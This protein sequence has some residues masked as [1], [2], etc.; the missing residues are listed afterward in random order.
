MS[1]SRFRGQLLC[2]QFLNCNSHEE[3][4][5][6]KFSDLILNKSQA[7]AYS[8]KLRQNA[9]DLFY[10]GFI[11]LNEGLIGIENKQ[12]SWAVVKCYYSIFYLLRAD[13]ALKDFGIIRH[14]SLYYLFAEEG[15]SPITKGNRNYSTDHKCVINYHKD[16][17]SNSDILL[18]QNISDLNAYD[19]LSKKRE[20]I[21]YQE[22]FFNEP[23]APSFLSYIDGVIKE[24]NFN[25]LI[26]EILDDK[27]IKTFQEEFA[28]L[29]IP[30]KKAILTIQNFKDSGTEIQISEKKK[31]SIVNLLDL[32]NWD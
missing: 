7:I 28:T 10:K 31:G 29:A 23:D 19:W 6:A 11:S 4:R 25:A 13:L 12:Y 32:L 15:A 3:F 26:V 16:F 17:F 18:S 9:N 22:R 27:Y 14:K 24:G 5:L 1:F 21:N 8:A 20:Q 30:I 2:E